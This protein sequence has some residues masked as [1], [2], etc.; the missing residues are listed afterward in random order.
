MRVVADDREG[1]SG[2]VEALRSMEGIQ[3]EVER[4]ALGDYLVDDRVLFERKTVLDF[5]GSLVDG[6]LF[7]QACRLAS[8]HFRPVL[9]LEGT[10]ADFSGCGVRREAIQGALITLTVMLNLPLLRSLDAAETARLIRY[11]GEQIERSVMGAV[12]RPGYRPKGKRKRQLY[13]LQ[14]LPGIGSKR[15]E[16]LLDVFGNVESVVGADLETLAAVEGIGRKT[17]DRIRQ[18]LSEDRAPYGNALETKI[19]AEL[20]GKLALKDAVG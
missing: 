5:A 6:R 11:T 15:A 13:L 3:V 18:T 10:A 20:R 19:T 16:K 9:I 17:A 4:L 14:G 2:V 8:C 12:I 7:E 1:K